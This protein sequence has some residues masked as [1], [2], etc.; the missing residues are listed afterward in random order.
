MFADSFDLHN[1]YNDSFR[2]ASHRN[3]EQ[4]RN[5]CFIYYDIFKN[6]IR[7]RTANPNAEGEESES[8]EKQIK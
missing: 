8:D 5:L 2:H 6:A 1:F 4:G 7:L 3:N